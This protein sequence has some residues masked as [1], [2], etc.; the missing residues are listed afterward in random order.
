MGKSQELVPAFESKNQSIIKNHPKFQNVNSIYARITYPSTLQSQ[1]VNLML[2]L[3]DKGKKFNFNKSNR[4]QKTIV[5]R[6]HGV[7]WLGMLSLFTKGPNAAVCPRCLPTNLQIT[8]LSAYMVGP[9]YSFYVD[10]LNQIQSG[11]I[12]DTTGKEKNIE[13]S[14]S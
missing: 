10:L 14:A 7:V 2:Q 4:L 1:N 9:L 11:V 13:R 6:Y 8:D 5:D 12:Y 3:N